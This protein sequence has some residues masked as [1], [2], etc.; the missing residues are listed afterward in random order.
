MMTLS[1]ATNDL[2]PASTPRAALV[3]LATPLVPSEKIYIYMV[4]D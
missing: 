3:V 2:E 4:T 1:I